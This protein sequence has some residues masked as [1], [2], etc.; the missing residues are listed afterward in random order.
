MAEGAGRHRPG[1]G[2][3]R[4]A[5]AV[6]DRTAGL[7]RGSACGRALDVVGV[8]L[9][10]GEQTAQLLPDLL[11][12]VLGALSAAQIEGARGLQYLREDLNERA[13]IRSAGKV[14]ELII[15]TLVVQ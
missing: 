10:P 6:P 15:E 7:R 9:L 2:W 12:R 13:A 1:W 11:D 3:W 8:G 4:P 14:R 5:E